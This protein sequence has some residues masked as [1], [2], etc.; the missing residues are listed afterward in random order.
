[1]LEN[2]HR[3]NFGDLLGGTSDLPFDLASTINLAFFSYFPEFSQEV[4]PLDFDF[5]SLLFLCKDIP[6]T[7]FITLLLFALFFWL[8]L[9]PE[10]QIA[11]KIAVTGLAII[12]QRNQV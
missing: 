6:I 5:K 8:Q 2:L 1:V 10:N 3:A 12:K 11:K 4:V 9:L 7:K